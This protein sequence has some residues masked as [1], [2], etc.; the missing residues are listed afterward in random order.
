MGNVFLGLAIPVF[1]A[2][3]SAQTIERAFQFVHTETAQSMN[4]IA[5]AVR[6]MGEITGVTVNPVQRSFTVQGTAAQIA[7]AG[8]LFAG[9]DLKTP[10]PPDSGTHE[11]RFQ[12][13][14][15]NIVRVYYI[16]HGQSV[17]EFQEVATAMRTAGD[18]RRVYTYNAG[19]ALIVRGTED[20]LAMCD[21]YLNEIWAHGNLPGPHAVSAEYQ[22]QNIAAPYP[23]ENTVRVLYMANGASV[24]QFQELATAIRTVGDIRRVYTYNAP[25]AML[26]RGTSDQVALATWLFNEMDQPVAARQS[27]AS[28]GYKFP[29]AG[30]P[31]DSVRVFYLTHSRSDSEFQD[32]AAAIRSQVDTRGIY[33]C[34]SGRAL[35]IRGTG[36]QIAQA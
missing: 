1:A 3:A 18:I 31:A 23:N 19:R 27:T 2:V 7:F 13:G 12:S 30:D 11:Y 32:N 16:D 34:N 10:V 28:S 14:A 25:R 22:M 36:E 33:A 17:Q 9:L 29:I 26:V 20:Q 8:W 21:W 35:V 15:D 6:T 4:E 5:T 24:Q